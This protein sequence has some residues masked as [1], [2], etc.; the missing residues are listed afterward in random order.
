MVV[1]FPPL[2]VEGQV[3]P[4]F[5]IFPSTGH[6]HTFGLARDEYTHSVSQW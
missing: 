6:R 4:M 3:K 5:T 1:I 2:A